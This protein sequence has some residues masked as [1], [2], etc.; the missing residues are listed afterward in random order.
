MSVCTVAP[1]S[2]SNDATVN[3]PLPIA[4]CSAVFGSAPRF[5]S[6]ATRSV[7]FCTVAVIKGDMGCHRKSGPHRVGRAGAFFFSFD[8]DFALLA[9]FLGIVEVSYTLKGPRNGVDT[10]EFLTM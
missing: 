3:F 2:N 5:K 10:V 4:L 1:A 6:R 8:A 7:S 9:F